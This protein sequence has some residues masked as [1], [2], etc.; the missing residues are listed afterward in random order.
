MKKKRKK[1][2]IIKKNKSRKRWTD[3]P[4]CD[5]WHHCQR[6]SRGLLGNSSFLPSPLFLPPPLLL[7]FAFPFLLILFHFFYF[8]FCSASL[9]RFISP[10]GTLAA[11][12]VRRL[13]F[14]FFVLF[15]FVY[16]I[17]TFLTLI[18]FAFLYHFLSRPRLCR[19]RVA[20]VV[21]GLALPVVT[22]HRQALCPVALGPTPLSW[23]CTPPSLCRFGCYCT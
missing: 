23:R 3:Q 4:H 7:A 11:G 21:V 15:Y 18:L 19:R 9:A 17:T 16:S 10:L 14:L 13:F 8:S 6:R 2:T 1:R 12:K 5:I 20:I 22:S